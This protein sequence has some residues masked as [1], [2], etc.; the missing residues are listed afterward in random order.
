M[1][2]ALHI[3]FRVGLRVGGI[4]LSYV[5][6]TFIS[7]Y[8]E[9]SV[10]LRRQPLRLLISGDPHREAQLIPVA[11]IDC[12]NGHGTGWY[13]TSAGR[14]SVDRNLPGCQYR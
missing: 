4:F 6:P 2:K 14:L 7:V 1:T 3:R 13:Q 12:S 9:S 5:M 10:N 11:I 8:G